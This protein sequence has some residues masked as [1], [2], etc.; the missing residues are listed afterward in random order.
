MREK[1]VITI[2]HYLGCGGAYI[3]EKLSE[4]FSIPFVDHQILKKVADSLHVSEEE[5]EGREEKKPYFWQTF[6]SLELLN[7][8]AGMTALYIPSGKELY[9]LESEF[10]EQI[11][12][13]GS[14]IILGRG[15][16]YIL[17]DFPNHF[18]IFVHADMEDRVERVSG[19]Y[20]ITAGESR[21]LIEKNDR[22]RNS[23]IRTYTKFDWLDVREYD[24]CLNTSGVG[25][26][27]AVDII[28]NAIDS[29]FA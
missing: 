24:I 20:H 12:K 14:A 11:A 1:C 19:L 10:I 6:S 27:H 25:L 21:K 28:K 8:E 26:D 22:E 15:G 29:R 4:L 3:G 18:S 9:S 16:R 23:Y 5:I 7:S 2:S 17:R 13:E